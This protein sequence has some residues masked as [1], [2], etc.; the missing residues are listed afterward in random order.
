MCLANIARCQ[1]LKSC[2]HCK[3]PSFISQRCRSFRK[4]S[5]ALR[6]NNRSSSARW[7]KAFAWRGVVLVV[8]V[9][10]GVAGVKMW[11]NSSLR[12]PPFRKQIWELTADHLQAPVDVAPFPTG[13]TD[14]HC[15]RLDCAGPRARKRPQRGGGPAAAP[16]NGWGSANST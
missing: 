10:A 3:P 8:L 13:T 1:M 7:L 12:S 6:P 15:D 4:S 11:V 9:I 5:M 14:F 16:S 2:F